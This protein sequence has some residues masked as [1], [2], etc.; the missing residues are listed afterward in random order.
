MTSMNLRHIFLSA[1][2]C[3]AA[4]V[5]PAQGD[6][7]HPVLSPQSQLMRGERMLPVA[8]PEGVAELSG[9][10]PL[11]PNGAPYRIISGTDIIWEGRPGEAF[12]VPVAGLHRLYLLS[13]NDN[14]AWQTLQWHAGRPAV[15][16]VEEQTLYAADHGLVPGKGEAGPA[17]RALLARSHA[18]QHTTIELEPGEYHFH[19]K[20]ALPLSFYVSNHD[21][22]PVHAVG[23]PLVGLHDVTLRG[24][25]VRFVFHGKMLP[26]LIMDS[27]NVKLEGISIRH[28]VP[29]SAEGRIV[30]TEPGKCTLELDDASSWAVEDG[31]FFNIGEGWRD[32]VCAAIAFKDDGR[33][34]PLGRAGDLVWNAKAEQV[35]DK[36]V[37]FH[38]GALRLGLNKGDVLVLRS[39]W[40]PHPGMLLYRAR[41]TRLRNVVFHDSMG[42]ALIAQRSENIYIE[43]GGCVRRKGRYGTSG[44][45]ATHFSNCKGHI[46]VEKALY[47]GMMDDAINVHAT[48][49]GIESVQSPTQITCRYMHRQAEGFETFL[50]GEQ[51]SFIRGKTLENLPETVTVTAAEKLDAQHLRL[52]LDKPLPEDIGVGDAVENADWH[53]R[54]TFRQNIVRYNRARG[55]LFTTPKPVLVEGNRFIWS[56]GSAILLAGDAQGWYESGRCLDV[57]I[58]ENLFDHN[59]TCRFQFTDGIISICPEIRHPEKQQER[60]HRNILIERNT[61]RTHRVPL[62]S[63]ISAS[64][65]TFRKNRIIYDN[66][67]A[68]LHE[69]IPYRLRHCE[70]MHLQEVDAPRGQ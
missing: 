1:T 2:C 53:A 10:A 50:P 18:S 64:G 61:F 67:Y 44:A 38:Q 17:L 33:M 59:L 29:F 5:A 57:K 19:E 58:V 65:V 49:L 37:T 68:P 45:D 34:V 46:L 4:L 15:L 31:K 12:R 13:S 70:D 7:N 30:A 24:R 55:A 28:A 52:T 41:N 22:H 9:K 23:V 16:Q 26:V 56:S 66:D 11:G 27:L 3:A 39:Y 36:R 48:C 54:V 25:G 21:Q 63:A 62:L 20:A 32:R 42:M 40:R 43:G 47:E 35:G 14:L 6:E 60:Y 8:V 69:G 51:L